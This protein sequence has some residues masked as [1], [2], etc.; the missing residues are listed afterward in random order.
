[1]YIENLIPG[2]GT[3]LDPRPLPNCDVATRFHR[4]SPGRIT[5]YGYRLLK[6]AGDLSRFERQCIIIGSIAGLSSR[7]P[8]V[9]T[10]VDV[11]IRILQHHKRGIAGTVGVRKLFGD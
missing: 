11:A 4:P 2:P 9:G 10:Q 6:L 5:I 7:R 8:N 1:M 3:M